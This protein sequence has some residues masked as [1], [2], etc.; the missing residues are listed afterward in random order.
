MF[1]RAYHPLNHL[2]D[3]VYESV[4]GT[5]GTG[6]Q[7]SVEG[8]DVA[9]LKMRIDFLLVL[10]CGI[11]LMYRLGWIVFVRGVHEEAAEEVCCRRRLPSM[12]PKV[13]VR[14]TSWFF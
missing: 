7:R 13:G 14:S 4:P 2:V 1:E 12:W 11:Y 10:F 8:T 5:G 9:M 6:P 3:Q